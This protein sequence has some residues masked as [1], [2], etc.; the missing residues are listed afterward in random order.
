MAEIQ[1]NS[2][3]IRPVE[4]FKEAW[5][6]IKSDYWMLFAIFLVGGLIGGASMYILLGAMMCGM[7][8]CYLQKIDGKPVAF[9]GLFKGFS[10][11][12][13]SLLVTILIVIPII[14]L[15]SA[16][17]APFIAAAVMGSKLNSD[18]L[19]GLLA[20]SLLVDLLMSVIMICIHTLLFF[21]F[22]LI[23]DRN[24]SAIEAIKTSA[25]AVRQN[26]GGVVG[27]ILVGALINFIGALA[28]GI[29]AYF[30]VPIVFA[31]NALAYRKVFPAQNP[32]QAPPPPNAYQGAGSYT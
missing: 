14:V 17:Y 4:C 31:G 20:G 25:R 16:V 29:G 6:I 22:P 7:F 28:C 2:G 1:F 23:V 5:E 3:V 10:Y 26:L 32:G 27:L 15:L 19:M 11:F 8:Y 18:E 9:E 21:A 24:L 12:V 30:T 13:P